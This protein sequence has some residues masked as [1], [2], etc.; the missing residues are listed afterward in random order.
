MRAKDREFL[1]AEGGWRLESMLRRF[2]EVKQLVPWLPPGS[3]LA[4]LRRTA[5]R[6]R[7]GTLRLID[8]RISP[9]MLADLIEKGIAQELVRRTVVKEMLGYR[10]V[11]SEFR[12][13]YEAERVRRQ[14]AGF[15]RLKSSPEATDPE[16]KV[17]EKVRRIHRKR[18]KELGRPG[19]G[20]K[21]G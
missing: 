2:G 19:R 10:Q 12:E 21:K 16:S 11:V 1:N 18:R 3:D 20:K 5:A 8:P 14:V 7:A 13:K 6:L 17:A 9:T 15:H 4:Y